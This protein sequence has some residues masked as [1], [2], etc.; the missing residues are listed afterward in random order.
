MKEKINFTEEEAMYYFAM[1]L[2]GLHYLHG[3]N[4]ILR[5]DLKPSNILISL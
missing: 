4:I 2:L 1:I 3:N 5:G